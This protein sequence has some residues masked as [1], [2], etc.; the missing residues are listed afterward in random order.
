MVVAKH[1]YSMLLGTMCHSS[2]HIR[3][4]YDMVEVGDHF[5]VDYTSILYI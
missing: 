3:D 4:Q 5:T 1:S 2:E